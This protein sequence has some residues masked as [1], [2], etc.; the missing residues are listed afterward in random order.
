M[1]RQHVYY[2]N[3]ERSGTAALTPGPEGA[4]TQDRL[5][6]AARLCH[7]KG[8]LPVYFQYPLEDGM[9]VGR[10]G[11][12]V[13]DGEE[14]R[15]VHQLIA[16]THA[17]VETLMH[18]RPLDCDRYLS[19]LTGVG[20]T[21]PALDG[22]SLFDGEALS[23]AFHALDRVFGLRA[24][25]LGAL[26]AAARQLARGECR[27]ALVLM[28]GEEA[29][30]TRLAQQIMEL[31]S[32]CLPL[33]ESTALRWSSLPPGDRFAASCLCFAA[34]G[35]YRLAPLERRVNALIDLES[36]ECENL[37]RPANEQ[38]IEAAR[39]LLA[40]DLY[41]IDRVFHAPARAVPEPP[42]NRLPIELPPFEEGMSVRQYFS[43]WT[44]ALLARRALLNN[45]AFG[46][47]AQGEW[48][49]LTDRLVAAA[50]CTPPRRYIAE[51]LQIVQSLR[52]REYAARL[53]MAAES[54]VDLVALLLDDVTWEQVDLNDPKD[55][56]TLRQLSLYAHSLDAES[57]SQIRTGRGLVMF[58]SLL[59][60]EDQATLRALETMET[61]CREDSAQ[62]EQIQGMLRAFVLSR[63][64]AESL[65][66]GRDD[67]FV[68][69]S[70]L[71]YV[72]FVDGVPD[73]R[74]LN[75]LEQLI[76]QNCGER[77]MRHYEAR[78]D[79]QRRRMSTRSIR[80]VKRNHWLWALYAVLTL[81]ALTGA[82]LL[83]S[84][85]M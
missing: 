16:E 1:I 55:V 21:L 85:L 80:R 71:A 74:R 37:P 9:A 81:G 66:L 59:R 47:F 48:A 14:Y 52:R 62:F 3:D 53:G 35:T 69:Y 39:A 50:E 72:R 38:E 33:E 54:L 83:L 63:C 18:V 41:W 79:D 29:E 26:I 31:I 67:L 68:V 36:G 61:L 77:A 28:P 22:A 15:L 19:S 25:P 42:T 7:A 4:A 57:L 8:A 6:Q 5:E 84:R 43:D 11:V 27:Q 70:M 17:D 13:E 65:P 23:V 30:V 49:R 51:M 64:R 78:L 34:K 32:R 12:T 10:C 76:R 2:W 40:H 46:E 45:E 73:L 44:E 20:E 60:H 56:E 24:E 75:A 82:A 58:Y